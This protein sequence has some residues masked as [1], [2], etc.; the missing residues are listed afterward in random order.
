[1]DA[2]ATTD[3]DLLR[4]WDR[5]RDEAAFR[6]LCERYASLVSAACRR[7]GSPDADEA[8]QAVFIVLA[9]RAG[10][11]AGDHLAG[12]LVGTARRVVAR[13]RRAAARR[14]RHEQEAVVPSRSADPAD[15][16][17]AEALP[18]LDDA[19]ASLS[20]GRREAVLRFHLQGKP[21]AVVAAELGCSVGAVKTRVHEG[22]EALRRF[23]ARRGVTLGATALVAGLA[24]EA[25]AAVPATVAGCVQAGSLPTASATALAAGVANAMFA[26]SALLAAAAALLASASLAVVAAAAGEAPA[27]AVS[28]PPAPAAT[29]DPEANAALDWWRAMHALPAADSAIAQLAAAKRPRLP[30]PVADAYFTG[31]AWAVVLFVRGAAAPYCAWGIDGAQDG[32]HTLL[33]HISDFHRLHRLVLLRARWHAQRGEA[34]A[35]VD[36]LIAGLRAVRLVAGLHPSLI[37]VMVAFSRESQA[38]ATAA[39]LAPGMPPEQRR[40]L[41]AALPI[42][43]A[44]EIGDHLCL[45]LDLELAVARRECGRLLGMPLTDRTAWIDGAGRPA[46]AR[47]GDAAALSDDG[48]RAFIAGYP[49]EI[50]RWQQHLRRPLGERLTPLAPPIPADDPAAHPLLRTLAPAIDPLSAAEVRLL[51]RRAL[52]VAALDVLERGD[53]ALADHRDPV[54]GLPFRREAAE[55]GFRLIADGAKEPIELPVGAAPA[56]EAAAGAGGAGAADF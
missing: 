53:Q 28:P 17:W 54:R 21:Q 2:A 52:L 11:V 40:R 8:T 26:K 22:V 32:V 33:P 48:I 35:A 27:A 34:T 38:I 31:Q 9:R 37:E 55:G 13:Q 41:A 5:R 51:V 14:R 39:E 29:L 19:L 49:A 10:T 42:L 36:D 18:H 16:A 45:A 44:R 4:A 50:A 7:Q 12:W 20:P 3:A 30:D 24:G 56:Q 47:A 43:P 23:L 15:P 46:A 25:S 6:S 1:M